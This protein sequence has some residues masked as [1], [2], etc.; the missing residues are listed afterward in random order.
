[1]VQICRKS[2]GIF[3]LLGLMQNFS[4]LP[5][6][7]NVIIV[8]GLWAWEQRQQVTKFSRCFKQPFSLLF[9]ILPLHYVAWHYCCQQ[10][11]KL[12]E[13][14]Q[15]IEKPSII[16]WHLVALVAAFCTLLVAPFILNT[17]FV[18]D[19][20][21][22]EIIHQENST[23]VFMAHIS[24]LS[25]TTFSSISLT[26]KSLISYDST[27]SW[28]IIV[29]ISTRWNQLSIFCFKYL[30]KLAPLARRYL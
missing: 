30:K 3:I 8:R 23:C 1:M 25:R 7:L 17:S 15:S 22:N 26:F 9:V 12:V 28:W 21:P 13:F 6:R 24:N 4:S 19:E 11:L 18:T 2:R 14:Q 29:A 5:F 27:R 10:R 20:V 16:D